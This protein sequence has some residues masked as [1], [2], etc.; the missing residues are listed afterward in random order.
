MQPSPS[1][2]IAMAARA[3]M[4]QGRDVIDLSLGEPDFEPPPHVSAAAIEAIRAGG[5][6]YGASAGSDALRAAIAEKFRRD[7]GLHYAPDQITVANGAKQLLFDAFMVSLEAGDEVLIPSPCWVSYGDIVS[8]HGGRPIFLPCSGEQGFKLS[9]DRLEAAITSDTRWIML[10]SPSNPTGAIYSRDE[11]RALGDV[12]VRHPRIL[13]LSDEIYEH[14]LLGNAPFV[15]FGTACPDLLDR[16]LIVNGVSKAYAMT[17]WRLGY[18]AGPAPLINAINKCQSQSVTSVCPVVQ[19]A[20]MAALTGDQD[21]IAAG[22]ARFAERAKLV[23]ER[24]AQIPLIGYTPPQGAFYAFIDVRGLIGTRRPGGVL[25]QDDV[26][27]AA[28]LLEKFGLS[29]VPGSAFAAPGHIRLSIAASDADLSAACDRLAA[30]VQHCADQQSD[31]A[32][33]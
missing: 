16:T 15:S 7:N 19:A 1:M 22:S 25:L 18:A 23:A 28:H 5:I 8:L 6:R 31:M 9:A 33:T 21:F 29:S 13:I 24:L 14:V 30:M 10:N 11:L 27:V 20:A 2:K 3:M 32:A 4:A 26:A 12:L 17:G